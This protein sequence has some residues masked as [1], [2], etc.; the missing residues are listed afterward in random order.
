MLDQNWGKTLRMKLQ[1]CENDRKCCTE[2]SRTFECGAVNL[3]DLVKSF[4]FTIYF[5][6]LATF[7]VDTAENV[8][9]KLCQQSAKS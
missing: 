3:A 8:P 9:L 5:K 4:Q 2:F 6:L 1:K 7:G